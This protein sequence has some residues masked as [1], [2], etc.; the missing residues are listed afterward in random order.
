MKVCLT[1]LILF[2]S[3]FIHAQV[4][5]DAGPDQEKCL[6]D[7]LRVTGTGLNP[8][9]T[10]SYQWKELNSGML[11]SNSKDLTLVISSPAPLHLEL[12]VTRISK[13]ITYTDRDSFQV[14]IKFLPIVQISVPDTLCSTSSITLQNLV[15]SGNVG[16]W[17]GPGVTGKTLDAGFS[18]KTKQYEGP[19]R[20]KYSY[21]DPVTTCSSSDSAEFLVQTPPDVSI[22]TPGPIRVCEGSPVQLSAT[23]KWAKGVKWLSDGDGFFSSDFQ[24]QTNYTHGKNDTSS[25]KV[26]IHAR[27]LLEGVCISDKS[28]IDLFIEPYPQFTMPPHF[29]FC[30]P[31]LVSFSSDV[32]KPKGS[33]N[34]RYT[35]IFGN[36][37]SLI[38]SS[39]SAPQNI[40]YDTAKNSWYDVSLIVYNQWGSSDN[41]ACSVRKDSLNY[42]LV[43]PQPTASFISYPEYYTTVAD[44]EFTFINKTKVRSGW[45]S[46]SYL[47]TFSSDPDDTSTQ[48]NPKHTYAADTFSYWV[49]LFAGYYYVDNI[50][51]LHYSC[52]DSTGEPRKVGPVV[53]DIMLFTLVQNKSISLQ[54]PFD[55][56][57]TVIDAIGRLIETRKVKSIHREVF[58]VSDWAVGIYFFVN[59]DGKDKKVRKFI[60]Y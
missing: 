43:L 51:Q 50:T 55:G 53:T 18:P 56:E 22:S 41:E 10:G 14:L 45:N 40:Q 8:G 21:T 16:T 57:L 24:T 12:L 37:D 4:S 7:T 29:V 6:R 26:I 15:P 34:L 5:A 52:W 2:L 33:A 11:V 48:V 46:M 23:V 1:L 60:K 20:A 44:P 9:D 58:D 3:N 13:N 49:N 39:N 30:E 19:Y 54:F 31:A 17:S 27:S 35:W 28:Y 42:V 32:L 59:T 25:A 38:K 36:G 47:W